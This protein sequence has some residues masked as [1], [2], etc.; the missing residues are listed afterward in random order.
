M[1]KANH[2]TENIAL[3]IKLSSV[4]WYSGNDILVKIIKFLLFYYKASL[5]KYINGT[6][7]VFS[8]QVN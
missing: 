1:S 3:I 8:G 2:G 5:T 4:F 7:T 6:V